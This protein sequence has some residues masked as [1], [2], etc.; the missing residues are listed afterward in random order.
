MEPGEI[1]TKISEEQDIETQITERLRIPF[2][3]EESLSLKDFNTSATLALAAGD[4]S[5]GL[6]F[7]SEKG[8]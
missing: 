6:P 1:G 7:F 8:S 4:I 5:L 2:N 3:L